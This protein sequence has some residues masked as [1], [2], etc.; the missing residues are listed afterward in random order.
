MVR[1][2]KGSL[3]DRSDLKNKVRSLRKRSSRREQSTNGHVSPQ[4]QPDATERPLSPL[5]V[6]FGSSIGTTTTASPADDAA[7]SSAASKPSPTS[8]Q[9][10]SPSTASQQ[11]QKP[12]QHFL[13]RKWS[14]IAE[15]ARRVESSANATSS[16]LFEFKSSDETSSPLMTSQSANQV[17][18]PSNSVQLYRHR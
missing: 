8:I 17:D 16:L 18:M 4:Q 15:S 14:P 7:Q 11:Q 12:S 3:A 6:S 1:P 13:G 2:E 10:S 9:S 5:D